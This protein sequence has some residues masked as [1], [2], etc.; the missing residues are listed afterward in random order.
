[1]Q[2]RLLRRSLILLSPISQSFLMPEDRA[3]LLELG[4][5]YCL[6]RPSSFPI[7]LEVSASKSWL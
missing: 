3:D 4:N 6:A 2:Q 7:E 5:W 1:M